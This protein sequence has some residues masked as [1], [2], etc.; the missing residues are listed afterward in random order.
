MATATAELPQHMRALERANAV[1]GIRK[2]LKDNI[3]AGQLG[4]PDVIRV[5]RWEVK[6]MAVGELLC[7][8]RGWGPERAKKLLRTVAVP[9]GKPLG[10]LTKRQRTMLVEAIEKKLRQR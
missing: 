1:R 7:S 6:T 2:E 8:Q 9:L 3:R 5:M 4:V 10:S